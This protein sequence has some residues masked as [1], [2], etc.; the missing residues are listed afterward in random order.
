MTEAHPLL[1]G[2]SVLLATSPV[3]QLLP[4][5]R[6]HVERTTG[7]RLRL[8][9]ADYRQRTLSEVLLSGS[10]AAAGSGRPGSGPAGSGRPHE[11]SALGGQEATP[12]DGVRRDDTALV[13]RP[14]APALAEVR[15]DGSWPGRC[16]AAQTTLHRQ[17]DG[18]HEVFLPLTVR[19]D[20]HGVVDLS[21]PREPSAELL[22]ALEVATPLLATALGERPATDRKSV[23]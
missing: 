12:D 23:V 16:F 13:A 8:W 7:G 22:A 14:V 2:L 15:V 5:V 6:A 4:D 10:T 21:L 9:L 11:A 17:Q 19:G 18:R 20:R 1:N 3:H